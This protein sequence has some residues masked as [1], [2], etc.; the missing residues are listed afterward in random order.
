MRIPRCVIKF[1][2]LAKFLQN[3]YQQCIYVRVPLEI[4]SFDVI[5]GMD[6]LS[7]NRA[8]INCKLKWVV[9]PSSI[10]SGLVFEGVGVVPPLYHISSMQE[11]RLIQKENRVFLCSIIDTHFSPASLE[12]FML[13]GN[14]LMSFPMSY[15]VPWWIEKLS[16]TSI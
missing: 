6:W 7:F 3:S 1:I 9:F 2:I 12:I 11:R 8:L 16:F 10:H 4:H 15:L 14:F 13:S 5:L